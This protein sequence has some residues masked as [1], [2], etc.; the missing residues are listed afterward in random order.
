MEPE[1]TRDKEAEERAYFET[2]TA[3][4]KRLEAENPFLPREGETPEQFEARKINDVLNE[5]EKVDRYNFKGYFNEIPLVNEIT[6]EPKPAEEIEIIKAEKLQNIATGLGTSVSDL[7]CPFCANHGHNEYFR[8]QAKMETHIKKCIYNPVAIQ[9]MSNSYRCQW[10]NSEFPATNLYNFKS[11]ETNC[12]I[13][14]RKREEQKK[15]NLDRL[16]NRETQINMHYEAELKKLED[17]MEY[18]RGKWTQERAAITQL[19]TDT[20]NKS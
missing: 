13:E 12:L 7:S 1:Q 5:L 8:T 14:R 2:L 17:K 15:Q 4:N 20:M 11:H 3:Y 16:Y 19:I 18:M 10:C 9:R 6:G